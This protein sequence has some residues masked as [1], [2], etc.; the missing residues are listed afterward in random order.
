MSNPKDDMVIVHK[1]GDEGAVAIERLTGKILTPIMDRP[2]WAEGLVTALPQERLSYYEKRLGTSAALESLRAAPAIEYSD[3]GW[4]GVDA[5]GDELEIEA[6]PDFRADMMAA[7]LG[8]DRDTGDLGMVLAEREVSRENLQRTPEE[9]NALSES[10]KQGF[11]EAAAH[12]ER[13][14]KTGTKG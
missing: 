3:L 7:A 8:I 6:N 14:T 4:V 1:E 5:E 2:G 12:E 11:G 10:V 13:P 9:L